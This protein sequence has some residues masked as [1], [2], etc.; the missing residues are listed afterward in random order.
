MDLGATSSISQVLLNWETAYGKEY[1]I[2]VS[3]DGANWTTVYSTTTGDG[4]IDDLD[5]S[6]VGRYVRM[7][8]TQRGTQWGYSLW[9]FEVYPPRFRIYLPICFS[10]FGK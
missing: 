7:Y 4:G 1:E 9:E 5:V 3:G 10:Q 2:Q 8:G 6:G